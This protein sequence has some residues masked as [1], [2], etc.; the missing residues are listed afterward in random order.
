MRTKTYVGTALR[1][2]SRGGETNAS[3][4]TFVNY[5]EIF[6]KIYIFFPLVD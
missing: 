3:R 5:A 4:V 2:K 6:R 1:I